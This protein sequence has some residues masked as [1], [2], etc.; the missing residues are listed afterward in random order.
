VAPL[1]VTLAAEMFAS[2]PASADFGGRGGYLRRRWVFAC[3][4]VF[5]VVLVAGSH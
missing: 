4:D 5:G 1:D 2:A 3:G